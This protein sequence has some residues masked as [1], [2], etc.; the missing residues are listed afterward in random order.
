MKKYSLLIGLEVVLLCMCGCGK[1]NAEQD[2]K[3]KK[4]IEDDKKIVS[5][6]TDFGNVD[7]R[8][9]NEGSWNGVLKFSETHDYMKNYYRAL[10][11]S[12]DERKKAMAQ[13]IEEGADILVCPGSQ[14]QKVFYDVQNKYKDKMLLIIDSEP[15][16]DNG[17]TAIAY[18]V[19][20]ILYKEQEVGYLAGYAA[21]MEGYRKLGFLGGMEFEAIQRFGYG[22]IQGAEV[23]AKELKLGKKE[24]EVKYEYAGGFQ[25]TK[26]ITSRMRKW[27]DD[28]TE[29]IFSCGGG[30]LYSVIE[31]ASTDEKRKIIG[32]DSDQADESEQII[33]SAMKNLTESVYNAL[34]ALDENNGKWPEDLAGKTTYEGVAENGVGLSAKEGSWRMKKFSIDDY[35]KA[36]KDLQEGKLDIKDKDLPVL[37]YVDCKF[38]K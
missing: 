6:I 36:Y 1:S 10:Y 20:C 35:N 25:P 24:I 21:V 17:K 29:V 28:G 9:F 31:A 37:E 22:Y 26:K 16:N 5:L 7:D 34:V 3:E 14:F 12:D 11:D 8:S 18:N 23:A 13:A 4:K 19:H 27:Y 2:K 15:K 33:F 30:I 38:I 32:V